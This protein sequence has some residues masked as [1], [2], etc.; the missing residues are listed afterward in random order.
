MYITLPD[1]CP[2]ENTT[3][4]TTVYNC[5]IEILSDEDGILYEYRKDI[6]RQGGELG[7]ILVTANIPKTSWGS[8]I[9]VKCTIP[10][11]C[12]LN[13]AE[14]ITLMPSEYSLR[15]GIINHEMDFVFSI[16]IVGF[17][18]FALLVMITTGKF[19]SV[20]R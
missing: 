16:S 10:D 18:L 1:V 2:Y 8:T 11:G 6:I 12:S 15:Y 19:A 7:N 20:E 9:T 17:S 13:G 3:L 5:A 14:N 4:C